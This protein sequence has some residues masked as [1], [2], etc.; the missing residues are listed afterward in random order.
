MKTLIS[1]LLL[2][3]SFD[4]SALNV[5]KYL[6]GSW[7][8]PQQNGHGFSIEVISAEVSVLYWFVYHPDGSPTF[9]IAVGKN[10]GNV[11]E[12]DA[13]YNSGMRFG[14]FNPA[15]RTEIPWG[16]IKITF[17]SCD[18]ATLEYDSDLTF[19]GVPYGSGTIPLTRLLTI[20]QMQCAS[21]SN[22]GLYQGNFHSNDS[23]QDLP[24][25][26]IIAPNNDFAFVGYQGL[27]G[28]GSVVISGHSLNAGGTA[29]SAVAE[30]TF[31]AGLTLAGTIDPE[32]R[33]VGSY[34]V[35]A[36]DSGSYDLYSIP[37]LYR[38][39]ISLDGI[40]GDYDATNQA[41]GVSGSVTISVTGE[42]TG[43]DDDG[44]EYDGNLSLPD[45]QFNLL[46]LTVDVSK[47]GLA[48][49]TYTGYGAQIDFFTLGDGRILRLVT[50]NGE[51]AGLF[52]FFR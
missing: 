26:A 9:I 27:V 43:S 39:T 34:Q 28:R 6:S 3:L 41:S 11:I 49:G 8:N 40:A 50:S 15:D 30:E 36:G 5:N 7:S 13:F 32:Y 4:A 51:R 46:Q 14:D 47:C 10:N 24:G 19:D 29:V 25:F 23:D 35:N 38:R 48:N 20:D 21:N 2:L 44:C 33:M 37:G 22:A 31:S 42:I 12:A 45:A 16:D 18:S 52:D 17:Q 1:S